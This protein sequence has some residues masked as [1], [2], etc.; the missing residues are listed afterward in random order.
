MTLPA[1]GPISTTQ[2]AAEIGISPP[3]DITG[4]QC[5]TLTGVAS[6]PVVLPGNFYGKSWFAADYTIG[7]QTQ[8]SA[9][10]TALVRRRTL[11][12]VLTGGSGS[13]TYAWSFPSGATYNVLVAPTNT[14]TVVISQTWD[15]GAGETFH[16][17]TDT[18]RLVVTDTGTG[19][20]RTVDHSVT[21][22]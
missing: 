21:I 17:E 11:T 4:A 7:T 5:R 1:S 12:A 19:L 2:I 18:V 15:P 6:G 10:G 3:I 20:V 13:Y 16:A 22:S 14:N 8:A 9:G